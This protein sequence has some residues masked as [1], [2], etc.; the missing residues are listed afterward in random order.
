MCGPTTLQ[1]ECG[2]AHRRLAGNTQPTEDLAR[3]LSK[4]RLLP[5]I[6][7]FHHHKLILLICVNFASITEILSKKCLFAVFALILVESLI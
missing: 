6:L 2:P 7:L 5:T 3:L 4:E 1:T